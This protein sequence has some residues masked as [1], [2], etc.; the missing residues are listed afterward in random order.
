MKQA[1]MAL[2]TAVLMLLAATSVQAI[3][4]KGVDIPDALQAGDTELV[5]NGAGVRSRWFIDLYIGA[6]Y[7]PEPANDPAEIIAADNH[8]GIRLHIISNRIT[9]ERMI[10]STRE[11][12][13]N[14]LG[15]N[16]SSLTSEIEQFLAFFAAEIREGDVFD[17]IYVPGEGVQVFKNRGLQGTVTGHDF[18]QALFGIWLS[19][20][21]AQEDLKTRML[22]QR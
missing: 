9:S 20:S 15:D 7:V 16:L 3:T 14:V 13:E 10:S 5:L 6:L 8:Q 21:P 18:K 1:I 11:G 2:S 19:D 4:I 17:L 22:G 12:F